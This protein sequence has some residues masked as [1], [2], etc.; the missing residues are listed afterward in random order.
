MFLLSTGI[1]L[2]SSGTIES[3]RRSLKQGIER[4]YGRLLLFTLVLGLAFLSAQLLG[5]RELV[6]QGVY[7][8]GQPHSS[9]F[10]LFTGVHG[11]HLLGGILALSYLL[12]RYR[13]AWSE[14]ERRQAVTDVVVLYWHFM[15]GLW[16]WLFLLLLV[17]R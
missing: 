5:W 14:S 17:W 12:A 13:H 2:A 15:D 3:A 7:L 4:R 16:V 1:I 8:E 6:A 11:L 9:F 10:Y